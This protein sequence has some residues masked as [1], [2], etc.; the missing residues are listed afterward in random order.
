MFPHRRSIFAATLWTA[1]LAFGFSTTAARA[2]A[3]KAPAPPE[4]AAL[5]SIYTEALTH[6][7][8]F[9]NLRA[10]VTTAPGRLAGSASY[11]RAVAWAEQTLGGPKLDRVYKQDLMVPHW[12]RGAKESVTLLPPAGTKGE[13]VALT[14]VALGGSVPGDL[15]AEVIE[16]KSLQ[17]LDQLGRE[18]I[19][20]KIIF[21]NRPMDPASV[22]PGPAYGGAGDQRNQGPGVAAK[23]GAAGALTRSL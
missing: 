21:F 8:A 7:E 16:V 10:L 9:E 15:T 14:A 18:K 6:G 11:A 19:A 23:F 13:G 3:D 20:G 2:Q 5:R 12:E 1:A 4:T 22:N 17:E